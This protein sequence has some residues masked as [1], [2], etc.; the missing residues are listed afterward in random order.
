MTA[1]TAFSGPGSRYCSSSGAVPTWRVLSFNDQ[2]RP[3]E[4]W[5]S[6]RLQGPEGFFFASSIDTTQVQRKPSRT[7]GLVFCKQPRHDANSAK[8][9]KDQRASASQ[10]ASTQRK[11]FPRCHNRRSDALTDWRKNGCVFLGLYARRVWLILF[12]LQICDICRSDRGLVVRVTCMQS[13]LHILYYRWGGEHLSLYVHVFVCHIYIYTV[14]LYSYNGSSSYII[15][16]QSFCIFIVNWA[17]R[18][19]RPVSA[20]A[21]Y[22]CENGNACLSVSVRASVELW[23]VWQ[24]DAASV[25]VGISIFVSVSLFFSVY[26]WSFIYIHVFQLVSDKPQGF[27][28]IRV[29]HT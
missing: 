28:W 7:S 27:V 3:F 9:F 19:C 1:Q 24:T 26:V 8:A 16:Q 22:K 29:T 18:G 10:A 12:A 25:G 20:V 17:V 23:G 14:C 15:C 21:F 11:F 13:R 6:A 2:R 5:Y 4:R